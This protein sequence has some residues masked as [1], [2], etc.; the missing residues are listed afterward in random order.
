MSDKVQFEEDN[1]SFNSAK[2]PGSNGPSGNVSAG[3]GHPQYE[4]NA[5]KGMA[6]WLIKHGLAKSGNTAQYI[7]VGFII[8]NII[9]TVVVIKFLL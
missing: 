8:F 1:F 6:G 2:K 3:Y 7:L 5:P 4:S 9:I